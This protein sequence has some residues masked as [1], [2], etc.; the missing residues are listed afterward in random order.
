MP[1]VARLIQTLQ[2]ST[3]SRYSL[4]SISVHVDEPKSRGP[5]DENDAA[6]CAQFAMSRLTD[7]SA[8]VRLAALELTMRDAD[9]LRSVAHTITSLLDDPIW[10]VRRAAITALSRLPADATVLA[11][12]AAR[13][14]DD[15]DHVRTAALRALRLHDGDVLPETVLNAVMRAAADDSASWSVRAAAVQ[16]LGEFAGRAASAAQPADSPQTRSQSQAQAQADI[17]ELL[18]LRLADPVAGVRVAAVEAVGLRGSHLAEQL[19]ALTLDV[20]P[21]V[22]DAAGRALRAL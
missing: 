20:D 21:Q 14:S 19:R 15:D 5:P 12:L 22:R 10:F 11:S 6:A 8:D 13:A 4:V 9:A 2:S 18:R 1:P 7:E 16:T 3:D 17:D